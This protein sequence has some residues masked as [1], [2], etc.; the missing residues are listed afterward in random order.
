MTHS[1]SEKFRPLSSAP[2]GLP[3]S[4]HGLPCQPSPTL[5]FS[6]TKSGVQ[7]SAPPPSLCPSAW[8]APLSGT[9]FPLSLVKVFRSLES[10]MRFTRDH[11]FGGSPR[12][13]RKN[14]PRLVGIQWRAWL[15]R[16]L[17]TLRQPA[18]GLLPF[19]EVDSQCAL[20]VSSTKTREEHLSSLASQELCL[21]RRP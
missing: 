6:Q 20:F 8:A 12:Q 1:P 13:A 11:R 2:R 21:A 4:V 9:S 18:C 14:S 19:V 16:F 5:L 3:W 17:L 15:P 7:P 10:V